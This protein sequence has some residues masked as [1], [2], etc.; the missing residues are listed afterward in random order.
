MKNRRSFLQNIGLFGGS[1]AL[2]LEN[3]WA[4]NN[5]TLQQK[6]A[7]K[8]LLINKLEESIYAFVIADAMGGS[9]ENML[10]SQ[11]KTQFG[12]WDFNNF[13]PPTD[14]K[15][16]ETGLGKGNGRTTDDTINFENLIQIYIQNQDHLDA[17]AYANYFVENVSKKKI[18][19]AEKG[20]E[21]TANDRPLWWPERYVYQR[22][23]INNAEPR[24]AGVGNYLNEG[25]QGIVLAVGA[26]NAG[27]PLRAYQEVTA[28]G[29]AHTESYALE[30]A[31][32]NAAAYAVA[33]Q[34]NSSIKEIIQTVL[35]L[36][37]DGTKM[38]I[39]DVLAV[40][41]PQD[42][43]DDFVRKTRQAVLPYWQLSPA[44]LKQNQSQTEEETSKKLRKDTNISRPSRIACIENVPIALASLVYGEGDY[45]KTLKS[46][47]FYGRDAESIAAVSTSILGAMQ[48]KGLVA[49]K[50]K[51]EV[52]AVNKRNYAQLAQDLF[53]T[54]E[55]IYRKDQN[56]LAKR[57]DLID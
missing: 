33:F 44:M 21:M 37:Q 17:Y 12:N 8:P 10:P 36:A 27:D 29:Q 15:D 24:T 39:E 45:L 28:F 22:L 54:I 3:L 5:P 57:K 18:F 47:L 20:K 1:L 25:F 53:K 23:A 31:G 43:F 48:G 32:V 41:N 9:I 26:V 6:I 52:D 2:S 46:S 50:L 13:L 40:T 35:E 34:K 14:K 38:A 49:E 51:K 19:I 16:L 30:G 7:S 56:R 4:Q 55:I 11:I 42:S